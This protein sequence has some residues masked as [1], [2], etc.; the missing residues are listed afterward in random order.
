MIIKSE[1]VIV[2]G[3]GEACRLFLSKEAS[4]Q[5]PYA[6]SV[7]AIVDDDRSLLGTSVFGVVIHGVIGDLPELV[8]TFCATSI[9]IAISSR[10]TQVIERILNLG[11]DQTV[12]ILRIPTL[13]EFMLGGGIRLQPARPATGSPYSNNSDGSHLDGSVWT[14]DP[15]IVTG[16]GGSIGTEVV[17]Q[18]AILGSPKIVCFDR[19]E[20]AL[21]QSA[22]KAEQ[23]SP[24][25]TVQ[26]LGDIRDASAINRL[27]E[28]FAAANVVHA[29]A[30]KHLPLLE[31]F[32]LEAWH[33]NVVGTINVFEGAHLSGAKTFVNV[34]TDKAAAPVS[35]L[36]YSKLITEKLLNHYVHERITEGNRWHSVRFGNVTRSR[37][38]AF[39]I[40]EYQ[41]ANGGPITVS[42]PNARRFF[43]SIEAAARFILE[44]P[45]LAH[46]AETIV[47][48]MGDEICVREIAD[49][50]AA[51]YSPRPEIVFTGLRPG[52]KLRE[53]LTADADGPVRECGETGATAIAQSRLSPVVVRSQKVD[54]TNSRELMQKLALS[55]S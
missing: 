5:E 49:R 38:S 53:Q 32:P 16:A 52:E 51:Q 15:T 18:L 39:E 12:S 2:V 14:K 4:N 6:R 19:D 55:G 50:I 30:L 36:G 23:L 40:F 54:E 47:P 9:V 37:G 44:S 3:G 48:A 29:A 33:T 7:V 21:L 41:A 24:G 42:D 35:V 26:Y 13:E 8:K 20:S 34:S 28:T 46:P 22:L 1:R 25:V 27:F 31:R 45:I 10:D 17:R 43:I 11:I